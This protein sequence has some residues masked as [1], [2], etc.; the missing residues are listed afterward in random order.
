[1]PVKINGLILRDRTMSYLE[2]ILWAETVSLPV[3]ENEL[4]DGYMDV[5][6]DHALAGI[7]EHEP[8][9]SYFSYEDFDEKS[10]R[11]AEWDC[12][13]FF[14]LLESEGLYEFA[15]QFADD[16]YVAHDFWL[17]RRGHGAGFW[18]GDYGDDLGDKL[19][20]L[21]EGFGNQ[22]VWVDES[23]KLHLDV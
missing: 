9:D 6:S 10:L 5:P 13:A 8:L 21:C 14:D 4:I 7:S 22:Y 12:D 23:G 1:M 2:T 15:R 18:D 20:E 17:T 16:N 3:P 11:K 19:T